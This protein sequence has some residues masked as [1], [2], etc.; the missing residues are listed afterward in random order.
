MKQMRKLF[1][2]REHDRGR[3]VDRRQHLGFAASSHPRGLGSNGVALVDIRKQRAFSE[4]LARA[5]GVNR[6]PIT[7]GEMADHAE[8]PPRDQ[9]HGRG[10]LALSKQ[11]LAAGK[12]TH[13]PASEQA[14]Q[15]LVVEIRHRPFG[16]LRVR[17]RAN[18]RPC[19]WPETLL[20]GVWKWA[21]IFVPMGVKMP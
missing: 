16:K 19:T 17:P 13:G 12:P 8:P 20:S 5:P 7:R 21:C 15:A 18:S 3:L 6:H 10:A 4:K 1:E 14:L 11:R 2:Q 9:E